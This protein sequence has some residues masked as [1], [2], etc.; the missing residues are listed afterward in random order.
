[1][2]HTI[3]IRVG[4]PL[5]RPGLE[6]ETQVSLQYLIPAMRDLLDRIRDFN[7]QKEGNPAAPDQEGDTWS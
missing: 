2:N 3:T 6:V 7:N 4:T 1:M 5:L